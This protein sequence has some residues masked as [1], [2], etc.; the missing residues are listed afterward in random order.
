MT[1]AWSDLREAILSGLLKDDQAERYTPDQMLI[2]ARWACKEISFHTAQAAVST[3]TCDGSHATFALPAGIRDSISKV[4]LVVYDDNAGR[5]TVLPPRLILPGTIEVKA[6]SKEQSR[7]YWE[8]PSGTLTLGFMP[9]A[10]GTL[11]LYY[12]KDWDAPT[13]DAS[14]LTFP[15]WM[16]QPF[17]YLVAAYALEPNGVQQTNIRQFNRKQDSGS[18]EDN[19]AHKQIEHFIKMAQR[20]LSRVQPQERETFYRNDPRTPGNK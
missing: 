14:V 3:F 20:L 4:G 11:T 5:S 9:A 19:T 2:Y 7:C 10:G 16:E 1:I 13:G 17:A 18:P 12:F 6:G 15:D 8:W